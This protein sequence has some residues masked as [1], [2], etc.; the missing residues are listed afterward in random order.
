MQIE[1]VLDLCVQLMKNG[2][3]NKSVA[4]KILFSSYTVMAKNIGTLATLSENATLLSENCSSCKCFWY[5]CAY[6]FCLH[7]RGKKRE[8]KSN[9]KKFHTEHKKLTGQND[10]HLVKIVRNNCFSS[11]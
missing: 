8:E 5:S 4:F 7:C 2:G 9:L 1:K 6:C 3:K 10:C 11:M